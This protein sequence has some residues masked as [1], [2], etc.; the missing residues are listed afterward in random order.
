MAKNDAKARLAMKQ[1]LVDDHFREL[2]LSLHDVNGL[3]RNIIDSLAALKF[4]LEEDRLVSDA[5]INVFGNAVKTLVDDITGFDPIDEESGLVHILEAF[6]DAMKR[7]DG[8][9][10]LP[11][12]WASVI[13][14]TEVQDL[15]VIIK[16]RPLQ[17]HKGHLHYELTTPATINNK[18][19][20]DGDDITHAYAGLLPLHFAA[21]LKHP[22]LENIKLLINENP[23]ACSLKDNLDNLPIHHCAFN[24]RNSD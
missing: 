6:P 5:E 11:L 2:S 21:S 19:M 10:W 14:N 4:R 9:S 18:D 20:P 12:H 16:E 3:M 8:R 13:H 23:K 15:Q 22:V 17:L 24:C 1:K 7:R